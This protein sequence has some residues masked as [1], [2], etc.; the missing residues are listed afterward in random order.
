MYTTRGENRLN[1][2]RI[3]KQIQIIYK[4]KNNFIMKFDRRKKIW[5]S[6][7]TCSIILVFYGI[8]TIWNDQITVKS[9]DYIDDDYLRT[10]NHWN[11]LLAKLAQS[12][13]DQYRGEAWPPQFKNLHV[14]KITGLYD[15]KLQVSIPNNSNPTD[16]KNSY[17]ETLKFLTSFPNSNAS[18]L[19][20]LVQME[21]LVRLDHLQNSYHNYPQSINVEQTLR[22]V[23]SGQPVR[24]VSIRFIHL[25]SPRCHQVSEYSDFKL[26]LTILIYM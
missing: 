22:A 1:S 5:L 25:I 9:I 20:Q 15:L 3:G 14:D 4:T 6:I 24:Q 8:T 17:Y 16:K 10:Q 2:K 26:F 7:V 21:E 11:S 18:F 19:K 23:R 12:D 13:N